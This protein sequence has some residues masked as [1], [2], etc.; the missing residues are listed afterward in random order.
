MYNSGLKLSTQSYAYCSYNINLLLESGVLCSVFLR[1]AKSPQPSNFVSSVTLYYLWHE[2]LCT[3]AEWWD[4]M[5]DQKSLQ[6]ISVI[7]MY[8]VYIH[9]MQH[10]VYT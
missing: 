8:A 1:L 4:S 3:V 10:N 7:R 6:L 9:S 5:T 2:W